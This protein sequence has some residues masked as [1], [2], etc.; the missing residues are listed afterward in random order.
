MEL[1]IPHKFIPR[2]YQLP[3]FKAMD[4][5]IKRAYKIWHRRAGKDKCDFN[6]LIKEACRVVGYYAYFFPTA[7]QG[8]KAIW[9]Q[10][11][12]N[13]GFKM[14]D[15]IPRNLI[16]R[17]TDNEMRVHLVNGSIIQIF[18]TDKIENVGAAFAGMVFSEW[19]LQKRSA[20]DYMRPILMENNGWAVFNGTPRGKNQA[21]S[22]Y[23]QVKELDTWFTEV[24]TI[25]DTGMV[26]E[27]M[28]DEERASGMTE[29]MVQQEFYCSFEKG[30]AGSYY[31]KMM[32]DASMA[33]PPRI[34]SI[35]YDRSVPVN[36]AWDLGISDSMVVW[37]FQLVG[38]KIHV[39]DYYETTGKGIDYVW[40]EVLQKKDYFYGEHYAPHDVKKRSIETAQTTLD[41]ARGLGLNFKKIDKGRITDG[42]TQVRSKLPNCWFDEVKCDK[43]IKALSQ[44]HKEYD[45][46]HQCYRDNPVHDWASHGADAFRYLCQSMAKGKKPGIE[47][48]TQ[49][50]EEIRELEA[51][52]RRPTG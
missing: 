47:D 26:T 22:M 41:Y 11:D 44:Y 45:E 38:T 13:T 9:N 4:S 16:K 49:S 18:G 15:H 17:K 48:N 50:I 30:Q 35:P 27:A 46:T 29:D 36:T 23:E 39:I 2:D 24:L 37:F 28:L 1:K 10:I 12:A 34:T 25:D 43:G 51:Q 7:A 40:T 14:M 6:F 5:G 19:S 20:W 32:Q 52:Y 31:G 42:I 33:D 8:R 21:Y 3:F